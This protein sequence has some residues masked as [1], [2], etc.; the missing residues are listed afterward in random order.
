[1]SSSKNNGQTPEH[2]ISNQEKYV[3]FFLKKRLVVTMLQLKAAEK[4]LVHEI[5]IL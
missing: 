5:D 1:M 2:R 3:I 4:E